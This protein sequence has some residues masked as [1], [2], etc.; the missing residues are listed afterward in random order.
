MLSWAEDDVEVDEGIDEEVV[1]EVNDKRELVEVGVIEEEIGVA[2][3]EVKIEAELD[4][5]VVGVAVVVKEGI[6]V[7]VSGVDATDD[8]A[9]EVEPPNVH[10]DPNGICSRRSNSAT[11]LL[12][13]NAYTWT[14]VSQWQIDYGSLCGHWN[15]S[16][17]G[18]SRHR[19]R[20]PWR[21]HL[22]RLCHVPM[23]FIYTKGFSVGKKK[24]L[25]MNVS[26]F[27]TE[28][29]SVNNK[30]SRDGLDTQK[31]RFF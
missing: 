13:C 17:I 7:V 3:L 8:E 29:K 26:G 5:E 14:K 19:R 15:P 9:G 27:S 11:P 1:A 30:Q 20:Q 4:K 6:A 22:R 28:K 24:S 12:N 2:V 21:K 16:G 18:N 25:V 10:N 23:A 31:I